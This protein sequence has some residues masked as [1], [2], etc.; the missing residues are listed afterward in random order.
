VADS[1]FSF[2]SADVLELALGGLIA[3]LVLAA[4]WLE[5][6]A[7]ALAAKTRTSMVVLATLPIALRLLLLP[8]HPVRRASIRDD[9]GHLLVA[10]TL[11]HGRLA[12]PTHPLHEFLETTFVLQQPTYSSIYPLGQGLVL[13]LGRLLFRTPWAGVMMAGGA[14]AALCY[15]ALRAWISPLWALAGG[16]RGA[17]LLDVARLDRSG[18]GVIWSSNS[19]LRVRPAVRVG[20]RILGRIYRCAGWM[21]DRG[22]FPEVANQ[23]EWGGRCNVGIRDGA[24]GR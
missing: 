16:S 13:A 5:G 19:G 10:D 18:V 21:H 1:P 11:L 15:W 4:P 7:R 14:L 3:A 20:K 12:N 6:W 9:F 17:Q 2:G 23:A 8:H 24:C 22:T